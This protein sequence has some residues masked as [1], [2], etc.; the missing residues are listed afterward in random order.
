MEINQ[1]PDYISVWYTYG[2]AYRIIYTDGRPPIPSNIKL[3]M[4]DSRGHW[5][6]NTLVS[7]VTNMNDQTWLDIVGSF[8]SDAL[9]LEERWTFS[10]P[11]RIDYEVTLTDPNVYREPWTMGMVLAKVPYN[12]MWPSEVWEG[13]VITDTD[14]LSVRPPQ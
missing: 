8:H 4:G 11:E 14:S 10:G 3:W 13:T 9:T 6:G 12:E 2:H 1:F 5:E 7:E